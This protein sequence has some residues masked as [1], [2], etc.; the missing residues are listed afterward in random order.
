MKEKVFVLGLDGMT[1]DLLDPLLK[2]GHMPH[3]RRLL[4]KSSYGTLKTIFPPLTPTAWSSFMTGKNPGKHGIYDFLYR[5]K[6]SYDLA[7]VNAN[8]IDG[9]TLWSFAEESGMKIGLVNI[10]MTYPP[11]EIKGVIVGGM[12]SPGV[13]SDFTFPPDIKEEIF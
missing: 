8:R 13:D 3:F 1:F 11:E 6:D 9:K 2:G 4:D 12:D 7:P 10:P 5:K